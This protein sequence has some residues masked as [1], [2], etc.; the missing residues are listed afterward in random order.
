MGTDYVA[1]SRPSATKR[2]LRKLLLLPWINQPLTQALV[3]IPG[4]P[5]KRRLPV[6]GTSKLELSGHA[7]TVGL[8]RADRCQ[9][10]KEV[11]WGK[12]KLVL[13]AD[14][15]ALDLAIR[16]GASSSLF[17]DIGAYTGMFAIAVARSNPGVRCDAY[18]IVP[19]NFQ[20]MWANVILNDLVQRVSPFLI[21]L[22][23]QAGVLR[24][25]ASLHSG[26]LASSVALDAISESGIEIPI[27]TL[28]EQY[29]DFRGRL[30]LKIDVEGF[31][32]AVFQGGEKL[33][34]RVMPDMICEVLRRTKHVL[35]MQ[36]F[37][38]DC[39]YRLIHITNAGLRPL[40]CIVA[41][42]DERD[43]LFTNR[44]DQELK[45]LGLPFAN[46]TAIGSL[47]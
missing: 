33:I 35:S 12:G 29:K 34:R 2:L 15:F 40:P 1:L 26:V 16:L 31:E 18:E 17:L 24:V 22:G 45:A 47:H 38:V 41:A 43:W 7:Q 28:D 25:P 42:R 23:S 39:G 20:L 27:S 21:G 36:D 8:L 32:W 9:V 44:S 5:W 4:M 37:L 46:D 19:E 14:R 6:L 13:P 30:T 10:A 11:Y 3:R